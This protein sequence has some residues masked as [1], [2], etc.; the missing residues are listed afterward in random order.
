M[1]K[2]LDHV[3]YI[4]IKFLVGTLITTIYEQKKFSKTNIWA[5]QYITLYLADFQMIT[6]TCVTKLYMLS[7]QVMYICLNIENHY[8]NTYFTL[9]TCLTMPF[10]YVHDVI[11]GN[12]NFVNY[13]SVKENIQHIKNMNTWT[14]KK[15][16]LQHYIPNKKTANFFIFLTKLNF[17]KSNFSSFPKILKM[18]LLF[19]RCLKR[20][21]NINWSSRWQKK[22]KKIQYA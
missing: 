1:I 11:H 22:R 8:K 5:I 14:Y 17:C 21:W 9:H 13:N 15:H 7:M 10:M 3:F 19:L 2:F 16:L 18:I 6:T 4:L 20:K 12:I